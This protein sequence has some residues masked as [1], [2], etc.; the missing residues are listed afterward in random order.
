MTQNCTENGSDK[1]S[2][3][4]IVNNAAHNMHKGGLRLQFYVC[5]IKMRREMIENNTPSDHIKYVEICKIIKIKER[6]DIR[7]HNLY[8]IRVTIEAAKS[9]KRV[10]RTHV[11][12]KHR[13]ITLRDKQGTD[14][15]NKITPWH[16]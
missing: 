10:R 12:G 6:E 3:Y 14:I 5:I 7:K 11:I 8:E 4:Y 16:K 15:Q 13:M 1:D 2:A 9:L